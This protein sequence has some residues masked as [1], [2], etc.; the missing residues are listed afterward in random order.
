MMRNNNKRFSAVEVAGTL[1]ISKQTLLRYE[2]KKIIPKAKRNLIN[3]RREYTPNDIEAL[4]K[5][6]GRK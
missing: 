3:R 2:K 6:M 5:L 4:K 1:G